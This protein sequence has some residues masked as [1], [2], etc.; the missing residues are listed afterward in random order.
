MASIIR[1]AVVND[2]GMWLN[3][4]DPLTLWQGNMGDAELFP[5]K[6]DANAALEL[7][8]GAAI[9]RMFLTWEPA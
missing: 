9:R 7:F 5:L 4:R 2:Q 1:Y 3:T 8:K 6:D